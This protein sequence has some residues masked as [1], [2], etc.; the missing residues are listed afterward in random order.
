[1]RRPA[2]ALAIALSC[3]ALAGCL[4][5]SVRGYLKDHLEAAGREGNALVFHSDRPPSET[6]AGIADARKPGERRATAA[7]VFLRYHRDMVAVLPDGRGGSRVLVEDERTG[8]GH[9]Y[10]YVG[11]FWGTAS[12]RAEDGRGG[13]PG[14]GK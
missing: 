6:A 11:G 8:Y 5:S 3:L 2:A 14:S 4:D 7:G 1:V 12:G 13:G 9:F 10:P